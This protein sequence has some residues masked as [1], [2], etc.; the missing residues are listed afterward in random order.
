MEEMGTWCCRTI[1]LF[2]YK[3]VRLELIAALNPTTSMLQCMVY[4]PTKLGD[5]VRANVGNIFQHHGAGLC[6]CFL[7]CAN[8]NDYRRHINVPMGGPDMSSMSPGSR[9]QKL[10]RTEAVT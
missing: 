7:R 9:M 2:V 4:L 5:F 3:A 8:Q 1:C 10:L 6:F